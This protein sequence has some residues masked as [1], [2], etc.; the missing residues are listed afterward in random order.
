M[1]D[2]AISVAWWQHVVRS[3]TN[4]YSHPCNIRPRGKV[5][6]RKQPATI[7]QNILGPRLPRGVL[8]LTILV[9]TRVDFLQEGR[10]EINPEERGGK[11]LIIIRVTYKGYSTHNYDTM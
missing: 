2:W 6:K 8:N 7:T 5:V 4:P 1:L 9:Y 3:R 10:S 11:G